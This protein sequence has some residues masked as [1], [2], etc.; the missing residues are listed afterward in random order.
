[1]SRDLEVEIEPFNLASTQSQTTR[2]QNPTRLP[3]W[4]L[5][6]IDDQN[7]KFEWLYYALSIEIVNSCKLWSVEIQNK[8]H[9]DVI[10]ALEFNF[11]GS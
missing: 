7:G 5:K 11:V 2:E 6:C 3:L 1:M 9:F 4:E 8:K 10:D